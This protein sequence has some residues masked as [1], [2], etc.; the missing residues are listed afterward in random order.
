MRGVVAR[1]MFCA[2]HWRFGGEEEAMRERSETV[3]RRAPQRRKSVLKRMKTERIFLLAIVR[4]VVEMEMEM[5]RRP[6]S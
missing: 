6:A 1:R 4:V 2:T 3:R 5:E